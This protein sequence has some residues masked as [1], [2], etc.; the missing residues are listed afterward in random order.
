MLIGV[1]FYS[2]LIG[3]VSAFFT[4]KDTKDS[5]LAKRLLMVEEFCKKLGIKQDLEDKLKNSIKYS[6]G[7][8]AYLW[9]SPDEDIF[10]GLNMQ[11]KNEF[12]V[13]VHKSLIQECE[14]FRN[15]DISFIVRIIPL[16]K[17]VRYRAGETIWKKGD[18]SNSR[19]KILLQFSF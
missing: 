10:N 11:L 3:L 4:S 12:L 2:I 9:L 16:L 15:K 1:A 8:L 17:P 19:E 18:H 5:L 6:S 14:F 13:A 7:K